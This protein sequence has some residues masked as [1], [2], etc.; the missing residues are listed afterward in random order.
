MTD[1]RGGFSLIE[2]LTTMVV[3]SI[4]AAIAIPNFRESVARADARKVMTDVSAIRTALFEYRED[5][6]GLPGFAFWG[7]VPTE[8][9]PYL[10]NV[11]FEYK[12]IRYFFWPNERRGRADLLLIY[13]PDDPIAAA[14]RP[15]A[16]AG[17][18]SGSITWNRRWMRFRL[19]EDNQ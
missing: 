8:L 17:S 18:D 9:E 6:A 5:A 3:I 10:N 16:R 11:D 2:L 4:L 7:T 14:L 19:L 12:T 13:P 1:R 15:F